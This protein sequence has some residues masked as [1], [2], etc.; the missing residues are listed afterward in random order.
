MLY[1]KGL[2]RK[3]D[4]KTK[5]IYYILKELWCKWRK[6]KYEVEECNDCE[7]EGKD[8]KWYVQ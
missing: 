6:G 3:Y 1:H 7:V 5:P 2:V 8:N 4:S